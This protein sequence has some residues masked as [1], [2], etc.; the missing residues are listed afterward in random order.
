M[1]PKQ[2]HWTV[3]VIGVVTMTLCVTYASA[4]V[5]TASRARLSAAVDACTILCYTGHPIC[6]PDKHFAWNT[7]PGDRPNASSSPNGPHGSCYEGWCGDYHPC[8]YEPELVD[9]VAGAVET[10]DTTALR[11]LMRAN[12]SLVVNRDRSAVQVRGCA[13]DIVANLPASSRLIDEA[14]GSH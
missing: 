3:R 14:L 7:S 6:D 5:N 12:T 1:T 10:G 11:R 13:G 4:T 9:Q 2:A 8:L